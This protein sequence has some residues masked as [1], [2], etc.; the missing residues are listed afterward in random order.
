MDV[1]HRHVQRER[2]HACV[3]KHIPDAVISSMLQ[4]LEVLHFCQ[5][6]IPAVKI[7]QNKIKINNKN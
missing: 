4:G 6:T 2:S 3:C 7:K 1:R 5:T